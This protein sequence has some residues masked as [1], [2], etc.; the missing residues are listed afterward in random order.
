MHQLH[1]NTG[2]LYRNQVQEADVVRIQRLA[3]GAWQQTVKPAD[4]G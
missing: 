4:M 2:S 1:P 3:F